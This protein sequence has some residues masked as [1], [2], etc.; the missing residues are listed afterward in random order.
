MD[1]QVQFYYGLSADYKAMAAHDSSTLYFLTDTLQLFKGDELYTKDLAFVSTL[2]TSGALQGKMYFRL[3]DQTLWGYNGT[4]YFQITKAVITAIPDTLSSANEGSLP[5]AKAV[6]DYVNAKIAAGGGGS[7]NYVEDVTWDKT[8]GNL[9]KSKGSGNTTTQLTGTAHDPTYDSATQ[10]ITIPIWGGDDLVITLAKNNLVTSGK[11]DA[12][13]KSIILTMSN[14]N[15]ITIPVGSL[16]DIYV[17]LATP[18]ATT[19]VSANNEISVNV[20]VSATANNAITIE[21]DGLYVPFVDAYTKAEV[22]TLISTTNS[23]IQNH[24]DDSTVHI[25]DTERQTWNAKVGQAD[26]A[27]AK[28]QMAAAAAQDAQKKADDAL[29]S[30]QTYADNLNQ[31]MGNRVT[32]IETTLT[33]QTIPKASS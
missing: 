25:T 23:K 16:I 6:A 1:V 19:T 20:K 13:T 31:S 5:T 14:G 3:M 7:G 2:P 10:T 24:I 27:S 17:G 32:K 9:V 30:A 4:E 15:P 11:Y 26:L 22:D 12:D 29:A 8:N 28:S 33:W 21:D 18:T